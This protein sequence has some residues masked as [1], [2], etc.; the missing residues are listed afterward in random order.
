PSLFFPEFNS[1]LTNN[2]RTNDTDYDGYQHW[3]A[4]AGYRG[5]TISGLFSSRDKGIPTGAFGTEFNNPQTQTVD[6]ARSVV[7]QY[8]HS[9]TNWELAAST[10]V[11]RHVY[12]GSYLGLSGVADSTVMNKDLGRGTWWSGELKLRR[13]FQRHHLT[14]GSEFQD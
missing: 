11:D 3:F 14:F 1:P 12:S 4:T 10:S 2:G 6:S 13:S 9:W 8:E 5:F 7:L